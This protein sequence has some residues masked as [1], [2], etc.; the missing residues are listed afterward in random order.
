MPSSPEGLPLKPKV[1]LIAGIAT[2]VLVLDMITK[3]I[4][5]RT[6]EG[7]PGMEF[8]GDTIRIGYVMNPGVFL[9][10]GHALSPA[11]RFWLFVVGVATVL[12]L[13]LLL[14][15]RDPRF[16]R[17]EVIAVAAIVGGGAGNLVD[18]ILYGSVRDFLNV[19]IGPV[20]TGIFNVADMAITFGGIALLLLPLLRPRSGETT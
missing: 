15:L 19:G 10:L 9:S 16:R 8:L 13:L 18:R 11:M 14:T 2:G 4:A 3:V 6:L 12:V 20:R 17:A 7:A 5:Q 1:A